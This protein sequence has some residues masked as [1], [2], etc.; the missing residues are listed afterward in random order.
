MRY[1]DLLLAA[2]NN[3]TRGMSP[4]QSAAIDAVGIAD[5]LFPE[6]SQAVSE[7]AA[8]NESKRSLLRREKSLTLVAGAATLSDDVLVKFIADAT[9]F[10][11]TMLSRRYGWRDY[12][13]FVRWNDPRLGI[14]TVQGGT[15][16]LVRDPGQQ[17]TVPLVATG[18]RTLVVPCSVEK[19]ALATDA[20]DAPAVI[21][22]DLT[23]ALSEALRGQIAT[24]AGE[25]V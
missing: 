1:Q 25:R 18:A 13:N 7:T 22:S 10:D 16:L 17:F 11:P 15:Q 20:V 9:L 23:E 6:V 14:F 19:P 4:E 2:V 5:T 21:I 12:P 3:A 8:A 24:T